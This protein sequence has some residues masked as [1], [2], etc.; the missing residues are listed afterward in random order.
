MNRPPAFRLFS[1]VSFVAALSTAA[2]LAAQGRGGGLFDG[3]PMALST[4]SGDPLPRV[5][6][7]LMQ[8]GPGVHAVLPG[9]GHLGPR[10]GF[11]GTSEYTLFFDPLRQ[12]VPLTGTAPDIDAFSMG[13][14]WISANPDGT[15]Y[16]DP[17]PGFWAAITFSVTRDTVGVSGPVAIEAATGRAASDVFSYFWPG[18]QVGNAQPIDEPFLSQDAQEISL[19]AVPNPPASVDVDAHD[20]YLHL[21]RLLG[22][23]QGFRLPRPNVFFSVSEATKTLIPDTWVGGAAN[24]HLKSGATIFRMTVVEV[25]PSSGFYLWTEPMVFFEPGD[26]GLGN[27]EDVDA[28]AYDAEQSYVLMSTDH[29]V[30]GVP[31][32]NPILFVNL[33]TDTVTPVPLRKSGTLEEISDEVGLGD[34]PLPDDVD[35]ICALDPRGGRR[36]SFPD[37]LEI[38][39]AAPRTPTSGQRSNLTAFHGE[40][41]SV[42]FVT[43]DLP[44]NGPSGLLLSFQSNF[45][46]LPGAVLLNPHLLLHLWQPLPPQ[47]PQ[48]LAI[49]FALNDPQLRGLPVYYQNFSFAPNI[50]GPF[51]SSAIL[52]LYL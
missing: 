10:Y 34:S 2:P 46:Q 20:A 23:F 30:P 6:G 51:S 42:H 27:D 36:Q 7:D 40:G 15:L 11:L 37:L 35:S 24:A 19:Q 18:S 49:P 44:T 29:R 16:S 41:P 50:T 4:R 1:L 3:L 52:D 48:Q 33:L 5:G 8:K 28:L 43:R 13:L 14:D 25:P 45:V 32:R 26:L 39:I 47:F 12:Q 9:M 22:R 38:L 21:Y 17:N 31:R